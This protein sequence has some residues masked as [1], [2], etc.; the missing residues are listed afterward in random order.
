MAQGGRLEVWPPHPR[1]LLRG[2]ARSGQV[3]GSA[4]SETPTPWP[5]SVTSDLDLELLWLVSPLGGRA[6][7]VVLG[8]GGPV[9]SG[10]V[11][12]PRASSQPLGLTSASSRAGPGQDE[13]PGPESPA[14]ANVFPLSCPS[15]E[16]AWLSSSFYIKKTEKAMQTGLNR[17]EPRG[18]GNPQGS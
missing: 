11:S 12:S 5:S 16:S 7:E 1:P 10:G 3:P 13:P 4:Y 17:S 15:R 9:M 2:Q 8:C 6:W 14:D 18:V